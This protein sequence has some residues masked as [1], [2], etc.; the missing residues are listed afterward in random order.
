MYPGDIKVGRRLELAEHY[1]NTMD[2]WFSVAMICLIINI[3][4][5][6]I[7]AQ[8]DAYWRFIFGLVAIWSVVF[9]AVSASL[10]YIYVYIGGKII[11][12]LLITM[13]IIMNAINRR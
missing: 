6:V 2:G 7:L 9:C 10:A 13:N 4:S 12:M 1:F 3:V 5:I 8:F 11:K